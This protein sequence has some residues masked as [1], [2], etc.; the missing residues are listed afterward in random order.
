MPGLKM[1][2]KKKKALIKLDN[3]TQCFSTE[4]KANISH[5]QIIPFGTKQTHKLFHIK[6]SPLM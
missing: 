6:P 3:Y 2:D 1:L 4:N 5:I